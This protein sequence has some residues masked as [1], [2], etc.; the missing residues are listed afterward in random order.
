[1]IYLLWDDD[2]IMLA[3][4]DDVAEINQ[5]DLLN[6]CAATVELDQDV[7][8]PEIA[9]VHAERMDRGQEVAEHSGQVCQV[10]KASRAGDDPVELTVPYAVMWHR[11]SLA[12]LPIH[13]TNRIK[14]IP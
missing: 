13:Q 4:I 7:L 1:M 3:D 5:F 12:L 11:L 8:G 9:V 10:A 6:F 14:G 2:L